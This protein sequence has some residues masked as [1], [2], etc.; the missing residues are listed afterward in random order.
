MNPQLISVSI[1]IVAISVYQ[2]NMKLVSSE[3]NPLHVLVTI[4]STAL[5]C[6]LAAVKF[7][8]AEQ[9]ATKVPFFPNFPLPAVIVGIAIVGIELG[10]LMMFR[11]GWHLA[12]APLVTMGGA[13]IILVFIG[14]LF[15]QQAITVRSVSGL[16]VILF[17]LYLLAP[18]EI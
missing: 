10:Y 2:T 13:A 5:I 6:T 11:S 9:L 8:P 4:F 17:G 7:F 16:L 12:A 1:V 14:A 3:L 18:K 15:F